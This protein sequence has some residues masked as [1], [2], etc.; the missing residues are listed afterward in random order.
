M[1]ES[2]NPPNDVDLLV[3]RAIAPSHPSKIPVINTKIENNRRFRKIP[4]EMELNI[5]K[6]SIITVAR[7]GETPSLIKPFAISFTK[8]LKIYLSLYFDDNY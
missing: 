1:T 8:G 6:Q 7:F 3:N 5:E 2:K 4:I